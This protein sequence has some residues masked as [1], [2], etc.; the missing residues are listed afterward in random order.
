MNNQIIKNIAELRMTVEYLGEKDHFG[1]WPCSFFSASSAQYLSP[2]FP[3]TTVIAR[4]QG[5]KYA[6][7][8]LHDKNV[9][10]GNIYHLFRLSENIEE[11]ILELLKDEK[12]VD[13]LISLLLN[14]D[15]ALN[16]I[17][18]LALDKET[19]KEGPTLLGDYN[20]D[21]LETVIGKM[22]KNYLEA[23]K[24]NI[25]SYPYLRAN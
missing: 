7:Q 10:K 9:G 22:A 23:F 15:F 11:I 4:Y 18:Q 3:K 12:Y 17:E 2:I 20:V 24:K 21:K 8:K 19:G 16:K 14:K 6:A 5:A 25:K 13:D 1:W